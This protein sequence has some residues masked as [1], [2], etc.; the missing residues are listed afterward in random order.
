M[1]LAVLPI[2]DVSARACVT[3]SG[4]VV[5]HHDTWRVT[6]CQSCVCRDGEIHCFSQT[7]PV[8][9]CSR[10]RRVKGQCCSKCV[11]REQN[12]CVVGEKLYSE[13]EVWFSDECQHCVCVNSRQVCSPVTCP[14][15]TAECRNDLPLHTSCCAACSSELSF[16]AFGYVHYVYLF[17]FFF[18]LQV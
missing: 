7:C 3:K 18:L 1:I 17:L 11:D 8:L 5:A 12:Y 2:S 15:N 9:S 6:P 10:T 13:G 4:H 16:L 14:N